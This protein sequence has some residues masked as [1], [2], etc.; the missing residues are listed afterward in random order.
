MVVGGGL[1]LKFGWGGLWM[2]LGL[3]EML[4][5]VL[6]GESGFGETGMIRGAV[7]DNGIRGCV[8]Q[9]VGEMS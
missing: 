2:V 5:V 7:G 4:K 8:S 9:V 3:R 1:L 6:R